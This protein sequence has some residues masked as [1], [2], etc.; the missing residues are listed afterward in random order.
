MKHLVD[1]INEDKIKYQISADYPKKT[2][3]VLNALID[4]LPIVPNISHVK[5]NSWNLA[6][7]G[8]F[9]F[10]KDDLLRS[11]LAES[12]EYIGHPQTI[13]MNFDS[14]IETGFNVEVARE[15]FRK[16]FGARLDESVFED[17]ESLNEGVFGDNITNDLPEYEW[18]IKLKDSLSKYFKS[19]NFNKIYFEYS[20]RYSAWPAGIYKILKTFPT[21]ER[22]EMF[23]T[24]YAM[25]LRNFESNKKY[26]EI[27]LI[28]FVYEK[29]DPEKVKE[30]NAANAARLPLDIVGRELKE[31]DFIAFAGIGGYGG[32]KGMLTGTVKKATKD[33]VALDSGKS[34]YANRCCLISRKDGKRIE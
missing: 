2:E 9:W 6:G 13:H 18:V 20:E 23:I 29:K 34:V 31:G 15:A 25:D 1:I 14:E 3:K 19:S 30:I 8:E 21:V 32:Y 28:V 27:N 4:I 7:E 10:N 11:A 24:L 5:R 22:D 17:K 33:Q 16:E 12:G 26:C